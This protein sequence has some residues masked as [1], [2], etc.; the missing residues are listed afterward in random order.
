MRFARTTRSLATWIA[1][2]GVFMAAVA[3]TLSHALR[4]GSA[5]EWV[6]VCSVRGER[7]VSLDTPDSRSLPS[8]DG[9]HGFSH[10]PYCSLHTLAAGFFPPPAAAMEIPGLSHERPRMRLAARQGPTTWTVPQSRAPPALA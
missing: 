9:D 1:A 7:L 4:V 6:S 3:P 8:P 2:L 10:C 5:P